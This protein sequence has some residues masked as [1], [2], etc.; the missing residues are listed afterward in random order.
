M[1]GGV[2][3]GRLLLGSFCLRWNAC[4]LSFGITRH[5]SCSSIRRHNRCRFRRCQIGILFLLLP[6]A[7][8]TLLL[9]GLRCWC[10]FGIGSKLARRQIRIGLSVLFHGFPI[11][12]DFFS[13]SRWQR[14][15]V[16]DER[17]T[18]KCIRCNASWFVILLAHFFHG[19]GERHFGEFVMEISQVRFV[20]NV[21][22]V[23]W[24]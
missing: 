7:G 24:F 1:F 10:L 3:A 11:I 23:R 6:F 16:L 18:S 8:R 12:F 2:V 13:I 21:Q 19:S 5:G 22:I 4:G 15:I 14:K 9:F 20:V 17:K